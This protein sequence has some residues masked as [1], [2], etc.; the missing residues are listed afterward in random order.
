VL[1][2]RFRTVVVEANARTSA[3]FYR[4]GDDG[5][6]GLFAVQVL[7]AK[8]G[9]VCVIDHFSTARSLAALFASGVPRR[10]VRSAE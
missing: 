2:R 4:V 8:A 6:W 5:E 7:E 9:K 10:L 3:G 1:G